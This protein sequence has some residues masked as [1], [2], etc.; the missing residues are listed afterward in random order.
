[1][2]QPD[3]PRPPRRPSESRRRRERERANKGTGT[4]FALIG[5]LIVIAILLGLGMM[6]MPNVFYI[7]AIVFGFGAFAA[8][9][10]LVWGWWLGGK[11]TEENRFW[12]NAEPPAS[13]RGSDDP[14][15]D[16]E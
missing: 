13:E 9:H 14:W 16:V 2:S 10:Y 1:M 11:S 3:R 15:L 8:F 4:A 6:V 7:P 5:L 12:E